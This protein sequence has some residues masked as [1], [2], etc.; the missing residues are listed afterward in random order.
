MK[1]LVAAA[2]AIILGTSVAAAAPRASDPSVLALE[3]RWNCKAPCVLPVYVDPAF[4]ANTQAIIDQQLAAWS[5]SPYIDLVR[6]TDGTVPRQMRPQADGFTTT[7][8]TKGPWMTFARVELD[9]KWFDWDGMPFVTCHE[10]SHALGFNDGAPPT[11]DPNTCPTADHFA[12]LAA[13]YGG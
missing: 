10:L 13:A 12:M 9:Y 4:P 1:I 7:I 5:A 2:A 11:S 6:T 8:R 3:H